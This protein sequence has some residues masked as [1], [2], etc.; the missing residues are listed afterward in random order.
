FMVAEQKMQ[1]IALAQFGR[2]AMA[3]VPDCRRLSYLDTWCKGEGQVEAKVSGKRAVLTVK[4]DI[5]FTVACR[6]E[7][8]RWKIDYA[9]CEDFQRDDPKEIRR[10]AQIFRKNADELDA[11]TQDIKKHRVRNL[12]ELRKAL[13]TRLPPTASP[14]GAK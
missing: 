10:V 13:G 2:G 3:V 11:I 7:G 1:E 5:E 9:Q 6:R 4:A 14:D 12:E 8:R